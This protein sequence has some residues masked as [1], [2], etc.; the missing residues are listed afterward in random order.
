MKGLRPFGDILG[1]MTP[2]LS[3]NLKQVNL[4]Q[5]DVYDSCS[6]I[7]LEIKSLG[8]K[9]HAYVPWVEEPKDDSLGSTDKSAFE[10]WKTFTDSEKRETL[11]DW[12]KNQPT[13]IEAP[14]PRKE[15]L[16]S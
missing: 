13:A 14:R 6:E 9:Y 16:N 1:G 11:L 10:R 15:S 7:E 8:G 12:V 5:T 4:S 3:L 2:K